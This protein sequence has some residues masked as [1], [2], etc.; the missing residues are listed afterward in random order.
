MLYIVLY[1]RNV[2]NKIRISFN[3]AAKKQIL[4]TI[5][6][7]TFSTT[8]SSNKKR[9]MY[10]T[11]AQ[12]L[13]LVLTVRCSF[14]VFWHLIW[15]TCYSWSELPTAC[16]ESLGCY[17]GILKLFW[18]VLLKSKRHVRTWENTSSKTFRLH[19]INLMDSQLLFSEEYY[20]RKNHRLMNFYSLMF[21]PILFSLRKIKY[22]AV[23]YQPV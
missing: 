14:V 1:L 10:L 22:L 15:Y 3:T 13:C 17:S 11:R 2:K 23:L 6:T 18:T 5:L 9:L 7:I 21:S 12:S 16:V 8:N 20:C 19:K 4:S